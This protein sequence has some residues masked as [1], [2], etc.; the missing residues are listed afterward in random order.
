MV[1]IKDFS[2]PFK[3]LLKTIENHLGFVIL[4]FFVIIILYATWIFYNFVY[5][6]IS[7]LPQVSFE[8]VEIKKA[9]FEKVI[10]RIELREKN[11]LEA[12]EK[13]YKDVFK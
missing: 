2:K 9:V 5:K 10:N 8:K 1:N 3:K 13:E 6:S 4:I 11:I 12:T 7:A